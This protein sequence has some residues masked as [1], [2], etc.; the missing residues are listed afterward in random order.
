VAYEGVYVVSR[1]YLCF[2]FNEV[3]PARTGAPGPGAPGT[4]AG[5]R[6]GTIPPAPGATP[7]P[8]PANPPPPAAAPGGAV[9]PQGA[10]FVLILRRERGG[11]QPER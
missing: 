11:Q 6:P 7:A 3:A 1:D 10:D 8:A 4:V 2:S 9:P 5:V